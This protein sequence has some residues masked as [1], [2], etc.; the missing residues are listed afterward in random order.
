M[1]ELQQYYDAFASGVFARKDSGKC[2]CRGGGWALSEV[3]T[4]HKCPEHYAGQPHPEDFDCADDTP[5]A[6]TD[7]RMVE[8]IEAITPVTPLTDDN[9]PF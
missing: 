2:R 6:D 3:D 9:I 7:L 4:L 1:S 8:A 5:A